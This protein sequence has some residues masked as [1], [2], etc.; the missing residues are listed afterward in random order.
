MAKRAPWVAPELKVEP[1][2]EHIYEAYVEDAC[3]GLAPIR[4]ESILEGGPAWVFHIELYS[5]YR[6]GYLRGGGI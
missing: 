4:P 5:I 2:D 6:L 3:G 1:G